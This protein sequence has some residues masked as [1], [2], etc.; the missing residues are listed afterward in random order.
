MACGEAIDST[1]SYLVICWT[2][3]RVPCGIRF[4]QATIRIPYPCGIRWCRGWFG[5]R[6][7]CGIRWCNL[8]LTFPYPCGLRWCDLRIPY[9]CFK[10]RKVKRYCYDFESVGGTCYFLYEDVYGCCNGQEY[11]WSS[12]CFF[13]TSSG[14]GSVDSSAR[15]FRKCFDEPLTPIGPCRRGKSLPDVGDLPGGPIDPGSVS[16]HQP[17]GTRYAG[18]GLNYLGRLGRCSRCTVAS[19]LLAGF[20]WLLFLVLPLVL[21]PFPFLSTLVFGVLAIALTLP[22]LGHTI[23]LLMQLR[24]TASTKPRI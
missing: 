10:Q 9:P 8:S 7:P 19:L 23:G 17:T 13:V 4:C 21:F 22:M 5:I 1:E 6:Y 11:N 18:E 2:T 20:G 16:P 12:A 3:I 15:N 14:P 24:F